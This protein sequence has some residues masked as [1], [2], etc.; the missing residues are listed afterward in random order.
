M[1]SEKNERSI[2]DYVLVNKRNRTYVKD[3]SIR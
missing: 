3:V 1:R 2:I